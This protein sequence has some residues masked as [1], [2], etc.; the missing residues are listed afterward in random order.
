[1]PNLMRH[2]YT[3]TQSETLSD[4]QE[5]KELSSAYDIHNTSTASLDT[6]RHGYITRGRPRGGATKPIPEFSVE[7]REYFWSRVVIG[8]PDECWPWTGARAVAS[9]YSP[10]KLYGNFRH[11]K[12]HRL[13]YVFNGGIIPDGYTIDHVAARGCTDSLCCNPAHLEPVTMAEQVIRRDAHKSVGD[14]LAYCKH[15]H[16]RKVGKPCGDCAIMNGKKFRERHPDRVAAYPSRQPKGYRGVTPP[17]PK[18]VIQ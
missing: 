18:G 9:P 16:V 5:T 15:L 11:F 3:D 4:N 1:M 10:R 8:R 17:K 12:V 14:G 2:N 6:G 7:V 13:A